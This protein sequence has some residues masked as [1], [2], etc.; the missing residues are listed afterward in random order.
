[1]NVLVVLDLV[2]VDNVVVEVDVVVV[3]IAIVLVLVVVVVVIVVVDVGNVLLAVV[4][5]LVDDTPCSTQKILRRFTQPS[6]SCK[7]VHL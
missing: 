6:S 2:V 5:V 4:E 3:A 1:M 7:F